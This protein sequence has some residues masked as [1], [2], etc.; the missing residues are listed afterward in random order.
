[1]TIFKSG[2]DALKA[3][4]EMVNIRSRYTKGLGFVDNPWGEKARQIGRS[5]SR[6]NDKH[7]EMINEHAY[8]HIG[9]VGDD[10]EEVIA[11]PNNDADDPASNPHAFI[12]LSW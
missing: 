9:V 8:A 1:L 2:E 6:L 12:D 4:R 11:G 5:T 3:D 10:S 7:W